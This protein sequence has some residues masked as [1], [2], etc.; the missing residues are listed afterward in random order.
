MRNSPDIYLL[1]VCWF[2]TESL[3]LMGCS[4]N[5]MLHV[6]CSLFKQ[7]PQSACA[8]SPLVVHMHFRFMYHAGLPAASAESPI[9][10]RQHIILHSFCTHRCV[11]RRSWL[12]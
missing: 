3:Q 5:R 9:N 4:D 2:D 7:R 10:V 1:L 6:C 8:G 12:Q 11:C